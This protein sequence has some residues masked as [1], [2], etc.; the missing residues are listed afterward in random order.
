MV[1]DNPSGDLRE[2]EGIIE[3]S[4]VW[5]PHQAKNLCYFL[6]YFSHNNF[7][8]RLVSFEGALEAYSKSKI[9]IRELN[10]VKCKRWDPYWPPSWEVIVRP[11]FWLFQF[12]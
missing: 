3:L 9:A 5:L 2:K 6:F 11:V 12:V 10:L 1:G 4:Q 8:H 7:F